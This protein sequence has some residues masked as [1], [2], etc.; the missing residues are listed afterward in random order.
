MANITKVEQMAI[1][2]DETNKTSD[3]LGMYSY[4][5]PNQFTINAIIIKTIEAIIK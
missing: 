2:F 4:F 5:L 1:K 3:S